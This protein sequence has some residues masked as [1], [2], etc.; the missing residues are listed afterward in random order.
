MIEPGGKEARLTRSL[1]AAEIVD[2]LEHPTEVF[3][4]IN[5]SLGVVRQGKA[6]AE[7]ATP[8]IRRGVGLAAADASP[9]LV[10]IL[11]GIPGQT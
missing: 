4:E 5:R 6:G 3:R 8:Q 10:A 2:F 9:E 7:L 11:G 1:V